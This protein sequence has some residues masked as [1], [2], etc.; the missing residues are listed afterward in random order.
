VDESGVDLRARE[1][2]F[3][4]PALDVAGV[5]PLLR[6]LR[7]GKRESFYYSA[8]ERGDDRLCTRNDLLW[9]CW[10]FG[11]AARMKN[12]VNLARGY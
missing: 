1:R 9:S 5:E 11:S 10:S 6:I 8:H 4:W 2:R 12:V 3:G 7:F